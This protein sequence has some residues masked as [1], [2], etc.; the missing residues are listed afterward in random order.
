MMSRFLIL[1]VLF[2]LVG[3]VVS[4]T[5]LHSPN[6]KMMKCCDK[7]KSTD[8]TP[9]AEATRL[10]CAVNCS[11]STPTPSNTS[12]NFSSSV[13]SVPKSISEQIAA[14]F[15]IERD[16]PSKSPQ[17]SRVPLARTFQPRYIQHNS[18]LI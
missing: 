2:A 14:L 1:F 10:C 7:A 13:V 16:Q 3:G 15:P 12:F 9:S 18:F 8:K 11:D 4:G 5:P 6:E 17:Y